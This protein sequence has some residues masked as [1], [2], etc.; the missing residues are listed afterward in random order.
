[1]ATKG[2][3]EFVEDMEA[4]VSALIA[5]DI[6]VKRINQVLEA[7]GYKTADF[8][9]YVHRLSI[10]GEW[11]LIER[12]AEAFLR[13]NLTSPSL[14]KALERS[15]KSQAVLKLSDLDSQPLELGH[16]IPP[17]E[18]EETPSEIKPPHSIAQSRNWPQTS[19]S[20]NP[21]EQAS[22]V[23]AQVQAILGPENPAVQKKVVGAAMYWYGVGG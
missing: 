16:A 23:F 11:E 8:S 22:I 17:A 3:I 10:G 15:P 18:A 4:G 21:E 14:T 7:A 9:P 19:R 20:K 12:L 13:V 6:P 2:Q 1:M 5:Q